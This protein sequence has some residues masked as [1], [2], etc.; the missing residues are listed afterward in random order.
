MWHVPRLVRIRNKCVREFRTWPK[1]KTCRLFWIIFFWLLSCVVG[2]LS[3]SIT[4]IHTFLVIT[5]IVLHLLLLFS[6]VFWHRAVLGAFRDKSYL[7]DTISGADNLYL[8][9]VLIV[10]KAKKQNIVKYNR[11]ILTNQFLEISRV[12]FPIEVKSNGYLLL[13]ISF[14][15]GMGLYRA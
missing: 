10:W 3:D 1:Y 2:L 13:G 6:G 9:R 8:E 5:L 4:P 11:T 14:K 7:R 15:S 12:A